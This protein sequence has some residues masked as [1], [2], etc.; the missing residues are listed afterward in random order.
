MVIRRKK[1]QRRADML[2]GNSKDVSPKSHE[3]WLTVML[4]LLIFGFVVFADDLPF[5]KKDVKVFPSEK[6]TGMAVDPGNGSE[7]YTDKYVVGLQLRGL[8]RNDIQ[9]LDENYLSGLGGGKISTK[10]GS[11][12]YKQKFMFTNFENDLEMI[13]NQMYVDYTK[14]NNTIGD[15]LHLEESSALHDI[16]IEYKISFLDGLKSEVDGGYIEDLLG[17]RLNITANTYE[18]FNAFRE[19]AGNV[20]LGFINHK[21]Q[22]VMVEDQTETYYVEGVDYTLHVMDIIGSSNPY[23]M[24]NIT[25]AAINDEVISGATG[26]YYFLSTSVYCCLI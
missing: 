5:L 10:L 16:F 1:G 2:F 11:T 25:S 22:D 23:V 6:I 18:I 13:S 3:K 26:D 12:D 15:Y 8:I 24:L 19:N 7:T 14:F 4:I 20:I 9:V 17:K 21:F